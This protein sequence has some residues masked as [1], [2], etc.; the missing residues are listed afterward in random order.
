MYP[1]LGYADETDGTVTN[2]F[3]KYNGT[4]WAV[5]TPG[6]LLDSSKEGSFVDITVD[7]SGLQPVSMLIDPTDTMPFFWGLCTGDGTYQKVQVAARSAGRDIQYDNNDS[8]FWTCGNTVYKLSKTLSGWD[9]SVYATLPCQT[10]LVDTSIKNV[11]R[12]DNANNMYVLRTT[13]SD[14]IG[15]YKV[16]EGSAQLL[17]SWIGI[18]GIK[19]P[20]M[21]IVNGTIYVS[22]INGNTF[23]YLKKY[24]SVKGTWDDMKISPSTKLV[25]SS[26]QMLANADGVTLIYRYES[27]DRH[28]AILR[29][30]YQ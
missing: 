23:I 3:L 29:Y 26:Y 20:Q 4:A 2:G 24:N 6:C 7:K 5:Q 30:T 18:S 13:G 12:F 16:T 27:G 22:C 28:F 19:D 17:G 14:Y 10:G 1:F 9:N 11:I 25:P 15:V 8:L 21:E